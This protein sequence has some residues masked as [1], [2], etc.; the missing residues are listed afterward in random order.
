MVR[1][2]RPAFIGRVNEARRLPDILHAGTLPTVLLM[3]GSPGVDDEKELMKWLVE[4]SRVAVPAPDSISQYLIRFG[5]CSPQKTWTRRVRSL[6]P[7]ARRERR[8]SKAIRSALSD[9]LLT[10]RGPHG[11]LPVSGQP[12]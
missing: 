1:Q 12:P 9:L 7:T 2:A 5:P 11:L 6:C 3:H 4:D 8:C 10:G